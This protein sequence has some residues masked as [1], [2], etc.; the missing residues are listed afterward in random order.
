MKTFEIIRAGL[1][2]AALLW[3]SAALANCS[4][5]RATA[6]KVADDCWNTPETHELGRCA[7][8]EVACVQGSCRAACGQLCEVVDPNL[9]PCKDPSRVCTQSQNNS[10]D[11]PFCAA[12]PIACE[13]AEDCPVSLP[14]TGSG[15]WSCDDGVCRFPGFQYTWQ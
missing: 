3:L 4:G 15:A 12:A 6:C 8:K 5:N 2:A 1:L 14:Q 11:L 9:N 7:P 13:G 10:V